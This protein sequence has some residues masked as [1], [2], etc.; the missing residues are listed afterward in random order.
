MSDHYE[1]LA[2]L[3]GRRVVL[4]VGWRRARDH[5]YWTVAPEDLSLPDDASPAEV[6]AGY[7]YTHLHA[8]VPFPRKIETLREQIQAFGFELPADV[9]STL[10]AIRTKALH[11]RVTQLRRLPVSP[12]YA[13]A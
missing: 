7:V 8:S 11:E 6:L 3:N 5:F 9:Y 12:R 13:H 4:E 1:F 10:D 2:D